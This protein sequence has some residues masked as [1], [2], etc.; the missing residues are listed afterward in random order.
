MYFK[1]KRLLSI[2]LYLDQKGNGRRHT[3][4]WVGGPWRETSWEPLTKALFFLS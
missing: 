4:Y 3:A 1:P 2:L